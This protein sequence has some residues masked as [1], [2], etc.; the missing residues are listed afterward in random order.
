M[1]KYL[2]S[3]FAFAVAFAASAFNYA[4]I[5]S[6]VQLGTP[7]NA[8]QAPKELVAKLAQK[9]AAN[10]APK[11]INTPVTK[12]SDL[13][14]S[15]TWSYEM[16]SSRAADP[17]TVTGTAYTQ[18]VLFYDADDA[19]GTFKI[20]GMFDAAITATLDLTTY[21]YPTFS[22]SDE[23]LVT[24]NSIT[25]SGTSVYL[26]CTI[27]GVFYYEGDETYAAG[28]YYTD[29]V[30]FV[31]D[32]EI[33][34][35]TDVWITR[36][37]SKV[38]TNPETYGQYEGY[39]LNPLWKPGSEMVESQS[40]YN[41]LTTYNYGEIDMVSP[42]VVTQD[43]YVATV[44]NFAGLAD[45]PVN[46]TLEEGRTWT[47]DHPVLFSNNNGDF[48]LYG[49]DADANNLLDVT[50][51]GTDTEL[52]FDCTWTGYDTETN[53]WLGQRNAATITLLDD[54]FVW[55][56]EEQPE[57]AMYMIGS[58]NNWDQDNMLPMTL[59]DGKWVVTQ[60][61]AENA[62]F[63]FRNENGDWFGGVTDGGNFIVTKEQVEQGTEL[64]L[65]NPGMDFQ[66]PVAGT[67]TFTIDPETMKLVI[68]GEWNEPVEET[69]LYILGNVGD[70]N[71]APNVGTEMQQVVDNVF[72]YTG[73]FND[74]S[75][76]SFT[77]KLADDADGWDA[78]KPYRVGATYTNFPVEDV[79]GNSVALGEWSSSSDNAFM[80]ANGGEYSITVDLSSMSVVF[81]K[82]NTD[83][84]VESITLNY[85]D[86]DEVIIVPGDQIQLI[87]TVLPENA[88]NPEVT[89]TSSDETLATVD[90]NGVVT[91]QQPEENINGLKR[92]PAEDGFDFVP[93]T[94]TA[95][96]V[97][98]PDV[99][100]S[101]TI[102][103][104]LEA[105]TTAISDVKA[106]NGKVTYVNVMG[107]TS[108][109]PF[110]G[111]NIIMQNGKSI[112]KMVK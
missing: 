14:G 59:T 24:Y 31:I 55:P 6:N 68:A 104:K 89:W 67:W 11:K 8:K 102:Y 112:G 81:Y 35:A 5:E 62:A 17:T 78:I 19:A 46:F 75:Y 2:L 34:W 83:I 87:A 76:F 72:T 69:H 9:T 58:F 43:N 105:P 28:W 45:N 10:R 107:H 71:W 57:P 41:G 15:Y 1:K 91:A 26:N 106:A 79:L 22:I 84:P 18:D 33:V 86:E 52:I 63:K 32:N 80:I 99:T 12:A 54:V 61:M 36:V 47:A 103:V 49:L 101:V 7:L 88:T 97:S 37:I 51:T 82:E 109:V 66:I 56:G 74:N 70:Q 42:A 100:A 93:V 95:A 73:T 3:A 53:F 85:S 13:L 50:G 38:I 108:D 110:N 77:K 90:E 25:V 60:E 4:P 96:S 94:I 48:V 92:A 27:K 23:E 65:S 44:T 64:E 39:S 30:A 21:E 40:A 98:N 29:N 20:A 111:V 16:A